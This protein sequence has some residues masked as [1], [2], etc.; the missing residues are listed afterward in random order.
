VK[1]WRWG[2]RRGLASRDETTRAFLSSPTLSA[3]SISFEESG[4][5]HGSHFMVPAFAPPPLSRGKYNVRLTPD[6]LSLDGK[7]TGG[8]IIRDARR[9]TRCRLRVDHSFFLRQQVPYLVLMG[10]AT[11]RHL[12][13]ICR[14]RVSILGRSVS[15]SRRLRI[16]SLERISMSPFFSQPGSSSSWPSSLSISPFV[17]R[18]LAVLSTTAC[19]YSHWRTAITHTP[20]LFIPYEHHTK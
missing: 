14:D 19:L 4:V 8:R 13:S 3:R 18:A 20:L 16:L 2:V 17:V 10:S 15:N 12:P 11:S 6:H 5:E 7:P 1:Q 9:S